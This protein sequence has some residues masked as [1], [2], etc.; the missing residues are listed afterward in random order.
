MSKKSS[1]NYETPSTEMPEQTTQEIIDRLRA[2][3]PS[4]GSMFTTPDWYMTTGQFM[5]L[6]TDVVMSLPWM[7]QWDK[8][9]GHPEDIAT[10]VTMA[11]D[12]VSATVVAMQ[13]AG[14]LK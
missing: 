1:A 2:A 12:T 11:V 13:R 9:P 5:D 10:S 6:V 7:A 3:Y 8:R 14:I 4:R